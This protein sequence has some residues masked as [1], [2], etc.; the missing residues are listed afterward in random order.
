ME[1]HCMALLN[2]LPR[3]PF[4]RKEVRAHSAAMV[5]K[6]ISLREARRS[7]AELGGI[8]PRAK[9]PCYIGETKHPGARWEFCSGLLD[10]DSYR[11][12]FAT[13]VI[14]KDTAAETTENSN[15][16]GNSEDVHKKENLLPRNILRLEATKAA[17]RSYKPRTWRHLKKFPPEISIP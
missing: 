9:P 5:T 17:W 7:G 16:L 12:N 11:T 6:G 14:L 13:M 15:G 1:I 2:V 10:V 8:A 3:P 4:A